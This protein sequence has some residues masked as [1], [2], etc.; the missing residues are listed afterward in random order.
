MAEPTLQSDDA[1][2]ATFLAETD[3]DRRWELLTEL[4]ARGWAYRPFN[5]A[6]PFARRRD[7]PSADQS[8]VG[9]SHG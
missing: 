2:K 5:Q 8:K 1:L 3:D 9:R 6:E 4:H 7:F